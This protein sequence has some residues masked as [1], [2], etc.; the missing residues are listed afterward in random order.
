[1]L[2]AIGFILI[3]FAILCGRFAWLQLAQ[4]EKLSTRSEENRL[5]L[6]AISPSRGL[7]FDRW[8]TLLADNRPA[9][10]LE[11]IPEQ[12][13]D[14]EATLGAIASIVYLTEEDLERF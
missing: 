14:L 9:Y 1:M 13:R 5:R 12:V 8:G 6:R 7:I 3:V 11:V 10:R 2:T 4:H